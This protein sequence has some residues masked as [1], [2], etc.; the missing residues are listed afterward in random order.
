M[1]GVPTYLQNRADW[2]H[3]FEFSL[4]NN[5]ARPNLIYRLE[6]L[7]QSKIVRILKQGVTKQPEELS[8][9]DFEEVLDPASPF[10]VS[11]LTDGEIDAML[12]KLRR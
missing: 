6:Q 3:A 10:V 8:D 2:E 9:D 5:D 12:T 4:R 1:K 11:G 7:K